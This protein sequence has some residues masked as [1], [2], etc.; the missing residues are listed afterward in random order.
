[1]TQPFPNQY[2]QNPFA[3]PVSPPGFAPPAPGSQPPFGQPP[4][5]GYGPHPTQFGAPAPAAPQP[6]VPGFG[7]PPP[8]YQPQG[9]GP[10]A[11]APGYGQPAGYPGFVPQVNSLSERD[12][13][14][15][16]GDH[17]LE[18]LGMQRVGQ[19]AGLLVCQFRI[20]NS[21][22]PS[23]PPGTVGAWKRGMSLNHP[24][25]NQIISNGIAALAVPLSGRAKDTTDI[26]TASNL[27][28]E[29][30]ARNTLD[31]QPILGKRVKVRVYVGTKPDKKNPGRCH[32]EMQ[33]S[34]A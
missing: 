30:V 26:Q 25:G 29:F 5:Q 17:D 10:P 4:A 31:G 11:Q 20:L 33:F 22:N 19:G 12:P 1:M 14:L 28:G 9:Y 24:A 34:P 8:Q 7:A 32:N 16:L 21:N 3:Q 15:P 13:D 6:P 2:Q 23:I 27:V 18:C